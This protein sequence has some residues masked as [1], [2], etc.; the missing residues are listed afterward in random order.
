MASHRTQVATCEYGF[1]E[2][3]VSGCPVCGPDGP[4][5]LDPNFAETISHFRRARLLRR[6]TI[7]G[8]LAA[9][10]AV[11]FAS[12]DTHPKDGDGE[13]TAPLVSGAV[14]PVEAGDAQN[15]PKG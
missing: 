4:C 14:P 7:V 13:A 8:L 5:A 15:P 1:W 11:I 2:P 3:S 6:L 9:L 10:G 12:V